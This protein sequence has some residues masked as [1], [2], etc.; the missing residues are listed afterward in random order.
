[1]TG[2]GLTLESV[3]GDGEAVGRA[4]DVR[5]VD[6]ERVAGEDNLRA[7]SATRDD[8]L[9]LVRRQVLRLVDDQVLVRQAAAANVRERLDLKLAAVEQIDEVAIA[10]AAAAL[11]FLVLR[12][13]LGAGRI[14]ELEVVEDR[15]HPGVE[16]LLDVAGQEAD[17]AAERDHRAADEE[18]R[19]DLVV[20]GALEAAREGEQRLAGAGLA[21]HGDETDRVVEQELE[22]EGLLLVLGADAHDPRR[23]DAQRQD[24]LLVAVVATERGVRRRLAVAQQHAR[25]R[26]EVGAL[27]RGELA[28]VEERVDLGRVDVD[29]DDAA[30]DLVDVD[31]LVLVVLGGEA[32]RIGA[33]AQVRVH[34]HEDGGT[35][36]RRLHLDD[37]RLQDRL[38]LRG[39]V[40]GAGQLEAGRGNGDAQGA[41]AVERD[42][43]RQ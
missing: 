40:E 31:A 3:R 36:L 15:L 37:G 41:A 18:T 22:R 32:V 38:I 6:L 23:G 11:R 4:V 7:L 28:L 13:V 30:V 9:H 39:L 14:E 20:D 42:A 10:G 26:H 12:A 25:V 34:R 21:E 19:V 35:T 1:M 27:R 33:D 29:L 43:G 5:V 16:L 24:H 8:R 2:E 17:V